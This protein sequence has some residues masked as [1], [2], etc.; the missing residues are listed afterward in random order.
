MTTEQKSIY[1]K[2]DELLWKDW[3]PIGINDSEEARD[4]YQSYIPRIFSFKINRAD[5]ET[6]AQY[7][8]KIETDNMGLG[9]NI[10]NCRTI[11]DKIL[12]I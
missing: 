5:K 2:I 3:D 12:N 7:L 8:Y 11:A 6:I 4:E 1:K 10:D 9:G